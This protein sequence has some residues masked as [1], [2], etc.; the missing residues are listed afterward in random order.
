MNM[1]DKIF[2][3][4]NS[5]NKIAINGLNKDL[6]SLYIY[7]KFRSQESDLYVVTS[8]LYEASLLYNKLA[9]LTDDL[10]IFVNDDFLTTIALTS[11][12]E[13]NIDR[14]STL[15]EILSSKS[16]KIIIVDLFG[17]LSMLPSKEVYQNSVIT[18]KEKDSINRDEFI[19]ALYDL[20]YDKV[21]NVEKTGEFAVRGFVIDI[22]LLSYDQPIRIDF[23]DEE[24]EKIRCFNVENQLSTISL[25]FIDIWPVKISSFD[26]SN[27]TSYSNNYKVI[28]Y[29]ID[30][31]KVTYK[32]IEE[33]YFEYS[34]NIDGFEKSIIEFDMYADNVDTLILGLDNYFN[35]EGFDKVSFYYDEVNDYYNKVKKLDTD[36]V[37]Y[38]SE[39]KTIIIALSNDQLKQ[40]KKS[41]IGFDVVYTN[42]N[43]IYDCKVNVIGKE[44]QN[45][46]IYNNCVLISGKNLYSSES[47][48][49]INKSN[50]KMG[51]KINNIETL[52]VGDYV[53]HINSGIGRYDGI[54]ALTNNNSTKDYLKLIYKKN[55]VL[56]VPVEKINLL[57]K[58]NVVE[59]E[60]PII[61]DLSGDKW[62]KTKLRLKNKIENI[63]LE[64]I[65][66]S[67]SRKKEK[68]FAFSKDNDEQIEFEKQFEFVETHDQLKVIKEIKVDMQNQK[69][70]DRLLCGDVG[71]GKTEVAFRAIHKAVMD[72][73]QVMYLCPTTI[74][75]SQQFL[76]SLKRFA[77][78]PVNIE[79]LNRFVTPKKAKVIIERLQQG[80]IDV[81]IGTHRLLSDDIVFNNLGLLVVDEEQRF[82]VKH[83]EKMK[84]KSANIDVLSLS[85]TPIPRTLQMSLS[86]LKGLSL[87]ETPPVNRHPITTYVISEND[88]VLKDAIYKELSRNG[89]IF[90]LYNKVDTIE[91][92]MNQIK[93]LVPEA[94]INYAHGQ[95]TKNEIENKMI[96]FVNNK[97]DI[98]ICTTIIETGIDIPNSNTLI[99]ID[100]DKFGLSQLYQLRGRVGR[101]DR[102]A[103]CYLMY[104]KNKVLTEVATKRLETIKNYTKLGSGFKIAMRDL[105]I[106][107]AGDLLG[108]EQSGFIDSVGIE[109]YM[110]LLDK[111]IKK[112]NGQF[113]EDDDELDVP[114]VQVNTHINENY[115]KDE[116]IKLEMHN[117][118]NTVDSYEKIQ[119]VSYQIKDR[120]GYIDENLIIYMYEEWFE[121]LC[122]N[123]KINNVKMFNDIITIFIPADVSKEIDGMKLLDLSFKINPDIKLNY[124]NEM[125]SMSLN[126]RKSSKHFLYYF[127]ELLDNLRK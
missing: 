1:F 7:N 23:F 101:S 118:I 32:K 61:N 15:K 50:F 30:V 122:K 65:K 99:V 82:G 67:A 51:S 108:K 74:L 20:G 29:D 31:L 123:F 89:Q 9:L 17:Y 120:F 113:V 91:M 96:D 39:N 70:M 41:E 124:K 102:L 103:Y 69:P 53:V 127:T 42:E 26:N 111:E 114:L 44:I 116:E 64:L 13:L 54:T 36:I 62:Q 77:K 55:A 81:L 3:K 40:F 90:I 8:S 59:G 72:N 48:T 109:L 86:T 80:K 25:S 34:K 11:S 57:T 117:L 10:L 119:E 52:K 92:K 94:K 95:M 85:A 56:Y 14:M 2:E 110:K 49:K 18:L 16:K 104:K 43:H 38:L 6:N 121:K 24:I 71:Y 63:A 75:S 79:L 97:F 4:I 126:T 28:M 19:N 58:Y 78:T 115:T 47:N 33:D 106:R 37:R 60:C 107:G 83:K 27:I 66:T 98:L 5:S 22:F 12:P 93:E 76:S 35:Y 45:G 100:A 21:S 125:I 68:G 73:K 87:I 112:L 88:Y 105:S 84:M 46:I